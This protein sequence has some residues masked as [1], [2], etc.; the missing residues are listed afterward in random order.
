MKNESLKVMNGLQLLQLKQHWLK[1]TDC[2]MGYED[3]FFIVNPQKNVGNICERR[4]RENVYN[5]KDVGRTGFVEKF[6]VVEFC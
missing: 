3:S 5:N 2:L 4:Q 6:V 1:Q